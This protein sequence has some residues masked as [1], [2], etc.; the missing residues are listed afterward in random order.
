[1][2]TRQQWITWGLIAITA[3]ILGIMRNQP[4]TI[5]PPPIQSEPP[6]TPPAAPTPVEPQPDPLAA[7]VRIS[8]TGVGCTATIIGPRRADGRYWALSAAH[9]TQ[10]LGERWTARFRD[11]RTTGLTTVHRN[12]TSDFAWMLTDV[13]TGIFPYAFLADADPRQGEGVWHAGYGV[14]RP[15]SREDGTVVASADTDGQIRYRL[16]VSSGDSGGGI[17]LDSSGRVLS[18]V[19]CTTR[20]GAL[21]DVYGASPVACK[22]G[23]IISTSL[24][25]WVPFP[26]PQPKHKE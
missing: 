10:A 18:P 23:Q 24:D 20:P 17:I 13:D 8:R 16:S 25:E 1:M 11:G 2:T 3:I 6:T 12:G 14:D 21:A 26:I 19:C 9:C 4:I 15:G 22:R 7:I 5:P